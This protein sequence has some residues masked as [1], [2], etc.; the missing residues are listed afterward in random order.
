MNYLYPTSLLFYLYRFKKKKSYKQNDTKN[1]GEL[2]ACSI[3]F[4][5]LVWM[6]CFSLLQSKLRLYEGVTGPFNDLRHLV[7]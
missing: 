5:L 4:H 1:H 2:T 7:E 3:K 6:L